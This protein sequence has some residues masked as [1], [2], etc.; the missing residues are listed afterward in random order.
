MGSIPYRQHDMKYNIAYSF[1]DID[2]VGFFTQDLQPEAYLY[3]AGI[4]FVLGVASCLLKNNATGVLIGIALILNAA[5]INFMTFWH[6]LP[7]GNSPTSALNPSGPL[8]AIFV[9]VLAVCQ[10]AVAMAVLMKL[11]SDTGSIEV[12][13]AN[14]MRG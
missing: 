12:D 11:N 9:I 13:N 2:I 3:V 14:K 7:Q 8:A 4:L 5:I 6:F 10:T 1:D